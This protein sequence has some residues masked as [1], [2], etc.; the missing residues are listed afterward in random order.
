MKMEENKMSFAECPSCGEEFELSVG[1]QRPQARQER[2]FV[3][4]KED[5]AS[6]LKQALADLTERIDQIEAGMDNF[7]AK[8]EKM[9]GFLRRLSMQQAPMPPQGPPQ[10]QPMQ[11]Q[12]MPPP[13][14]PPPGMQDPRVPQR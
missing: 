2:A 7:F 11:G 9:D 6:E 8:L 10:R 14:M 3:G 1:R 5:N 4:R 13:P 12:Q